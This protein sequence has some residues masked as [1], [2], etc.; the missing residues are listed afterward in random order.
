MGRTHRIGVLQ[1]D[2]SDC[3]PACIASVMAHFGMNVPVSRIRQAAGTDGQGTSMLGMVRAL[4]YYHFEARGLQGK[5]EHISRLPCPFIAHLIRSDQTHHYV[6]VF[7]TGS[8]RLLIMDP[9]VGKLR[10]WSLTAFSES[11]SGRVIALVPGVKEGKSPDVGISNQKRLYSLL[12]PVWKPLVQALVSAILYTLLG[13]SASIYL[14]KL[15]DHVFMTRNEGLLNLMSIVMIGITLVMIYLSLVKNVIMLKTG[16]VIDNQL[17]IS[18]YRHLLQLPQRF[19]DTM[20]TGEIIS[21]VNDAV[22]IRGFINDAA[23]GITVNVLILVFS[24]ATMFLL[25]PMLALFMLGIVPPYLLIYLI[26]NHVNKRIERKVMV[27]S[28]SLEEHFV[29]SLQA[30]R[31]IRQYNLNQITQQKTESRLNRLLDT[32]YSSGINAITAASGTEAVNRLFTIF[33]LWAGS[34]FVIKGSL[35][36]GQL[37]TFYALVGY[38]TGPVT[39]LIGANKSYQNALIAADRLFEILQ[40]EKEKNQHGA[41]FR[42]EQFGDIVFSGISFSYGTR[43]TLFSN[44]DLTI[45]AGRVTLLKGPSGSGKSTVASLVQHLYPVDSGQI[46]INGCDTRYFSKA[47]IRS[48]MG[49]VPQ[50]ICFLSGTVLENIA[51]GERDPD[52]E[53]IT[54]LLQILGLLPFIRDL[55][56]GLMTRLNGNGLNLSGGERQRL[57]LLRA[58]YPDPPLL[59]LD[60]ATASMDPLSELYVN[61]ALLGLKERSRTILLITHKEKYASIADHILEMDRGRVIESISN[62]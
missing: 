12:K 11:W 16:Q 18:Y 24:F 43:G 28:A 19:F 39:S 21:R 55:P 42:S 20:K 54:S 2:T 3:G 30:A 47:S 38:F 13:L 36:P 32:L 37:L 27:D 60:E 6:N 62:R 45:P 33:L 7:K 4:E 49:V 10:S 29:E 52:I 46:T 5:L 26:F 50:Q 34:F 15:T 23:I 57:A 9:S 41:V 56:D 25:H 53:R 8:K 14:G 22:K 35:S 61:R 48:L 44:L 58:L 31:H 17:I 40:L 59:I 51:P 1:H